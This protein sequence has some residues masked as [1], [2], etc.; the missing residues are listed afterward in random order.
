[1]P[2]AADHQPADGTIASPPTQTHRFR[3]EIEG[4]RAVAAILVAVY[5]VFLGRV[6]GGVDVFFV[7]A[8]FLITTSLLGQVERVGRPQ[9]GRFLGRLASRLLPVAVVV[10]VAISAATLL[11]MPITRLAATFDE[12]VASA[13]YYE[14]WLLAARAVD[15]LARDDGTS[16]LQHFWA[17]SIQGQ[18]YLMWLALFGLVVLLAGRARIRR[19]I[20]AAL[21]LVFVGSLFVSV[22]L[23]DRN[24]PLAYFHTGARMW[25]FA[26]G[27]LLAIAIARLPRAW[28]RLSFVGGWVG[29]AMIVSCG[30]LIP[31][32]TSFPGWIALWPVIG[33][34]LVIA[35]GDSRHRWASSRLLGSRPFVFVGGVAY[36]LYLWHWPILIFYRLQRGGDGPVGIRAGL[37]ILAVS[38][39]L[40]VVTTRLVEQPIRGTLAKARRP[41]S[42]VAAGAAA[43]AVIAVT[44]SVLARPPTLDP[45]DAALEGSLYPGAGAMTDDETPGPTGE[46]GASGDPTASRPPAPPTP[47]HPGRPVPLKPDLRVAADDLPGTH[48]GGC[49][50]D[51]RDAEVLTCSDGDPNGAVTVMLVGGSHS[52]HWHPALELIA[53]TRGWHLVTATKGGCRFS[54]GPFTGDEEGESCAAWNEGVMDLILEVRPDLVVT[55]STVTSVGDEELPDGHVAAWRAL[56]RKG[57]P[58]LAIRDTPRATTSRVDCLATHRGERERC[59]IPRSS[60]LAEVDPTT[61]LADPPGNVVFADLT[62]CVCTEDTCPAVIGNIVVYRDR[63]HFTATFARTLAPMLAE[64]LPLPATGQSGGGDPIP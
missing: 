31:V 38:F 52:A 27:G 51:L 5:H 39:V 63:S 60:T 30:V 64:H 55:T 50:Q 9:V 44:G 25:E 40:A 36:A 32:S 21:T 20:A 7:V 2:S 62:D 23:T 24:Q 4:L 10:L 37:A 48:A 26:A 19:S 1:M 17:L 13:L 34:L 3:P 43:V 56:E 18:F 53:E 12:V 11:W 46:P 57:I 14:N 54:K 61:L 29:L 22:V 42:V 16:P 49:H 58:V 35:A 47:T 33:A 15:Y 6:S 59:D 45:V 28:G 8:G 41:W